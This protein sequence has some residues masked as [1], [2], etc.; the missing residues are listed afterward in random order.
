LADLGFNIEVEPLG[1][2]GADP[3]FCPNIFS[4]VGVA[5]D[6]GAEVKPVVVG[7]LDPCLGRVPT[8]QD[9]DVV[10]RDFGLW[11]AVG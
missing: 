7:Y 11:V 8:L 9:A 3:L 2:G 4:V 5:G 1:N 10:A 6:Q